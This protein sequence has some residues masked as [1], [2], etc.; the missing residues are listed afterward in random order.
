[1]STWKLHDGIRHVLHV[2]TGL[3]VGRNLTTQAA[4]ALLAYLQE[5][6]PDP[7]L[8]DPELRAQLEAAVCHAR[9]YLPVKD[10]EH[11]VVRVSYEFSVYADS[12]TQA[13]R[14]TKASL[15][16]HPQLGPAR[17]QAYQVSHPTRTKALVPIKLPPTPTQ[18]ISPEKLQIVTLDEVAFVPRVAANSPTP[19]S[20]N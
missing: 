13:I 4:L 16:A 20:K 6:L 17:V 2:P 8:N 14:A 11:V 7:D 12:T 1:M 19:S 18:V 15:S 5:H 3:S 9:S 10:L